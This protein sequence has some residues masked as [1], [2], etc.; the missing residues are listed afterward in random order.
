VSADLT[1]MSYSFDYNNARFV[2]IDNWAAPGKRVDAAEYAYG[3]SIADQQAWISSRL[4][5][6]TSGSHV[7]VFSHQPLIAEN[8][9]DSPFT[10]YTNTD[11]AAQNAFLQ[12]VQENHVKYYISGHDHLAQ[13][14]II[15]SPDGHSRVQQIISSSN[16]SKF[17][18]PKHLDDIEWYGQKR[19][20]TSISQDLCRV[21]YY[22]YTVDG[23]R[24]TVDYY[25]DDHGDWKSDAGYPL[26]AGRADTCITPK[27]N[28][29][30]RETFGHSLN[31]KEWLIGGTNSPSYAVVRDS[32]SGTEARILS[33]S[34]SNAARDFNGRIL[35]QTLNTGWTDKTGTL[36]SNILS[37]WGMRGLGA[38]RTDTFTLSMSY[39]ADYYGS[40]M[41]MAKDANGNWV[42]AVDMNI[43][44][45]KRFYNR[46]YDETYGL[47]S[48]GYD[49]ATH[50]AWAVVNFTG[51]FA[52]AAP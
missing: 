10:G 44:G 4:S 19:R 48:Y 20:E 22:I 49:P 8:H 11:P 38:D 50:T 7:F 32:Y 24:V 46:S 17:Y 40:V 31:G 15:T 13:R 3:Y 27:F 28:F 42:N 45:I 9:Q 23:P 16:S 30:K 5:T 1:G 51:D 35:T 26:G 6:R 41:L 34:Y 36:K 21:G 39:A 18:T 43:G 14:S 29:I 12:S 37:L 52:V 25:A 33:G 47:G 2:I